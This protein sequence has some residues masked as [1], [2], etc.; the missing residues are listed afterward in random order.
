M[1]TN[2]S[3]IYNDNWPSIV[4]S[5]E[6][7][8]SPSGILVGTLS[9]CF[10]ILWFSP[11]AFHSITFKIWLTVLWVILSLC[12]RQTRFL[13]QL[14]VSFSQGHCRGFYLLEEVSPILQPLKQSKT[15]RLSVMYEDSHSTTSACLIANGKCPEVGGKSGKGFLGSL[16]LSAPSELC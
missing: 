8:L 5:W 1:E 6:F 14:F 10:R 9:L 7:K 4:I 12:L 2:V 13:L 11:L 3:L 16:M 15:E